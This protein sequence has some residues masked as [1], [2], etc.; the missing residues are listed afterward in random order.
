M[1]Y[2]SKGT[3]G[4]SGFTLIELLVVVAIIA[5]L[6]S[7]LLPSLARARELSKRT[8]CASNMKGIGTGFYTYA[9]ENADRRPEPG[10]HVASTNT[11]SNGCAVKYSEIVGG[12]ATRGTS[13]GQIGSSPD[14]GD[15]G[16][17][18][19]L[20]TTPASLL[21]TTRA[22]WMLVRTNA[23]TPKSFYCPSS[24]DTP[25]DEDNPQAYWDFGKGDNNTGG[26][27]YQGA[28]AQ[29]SYGYQVPYG[30]TGQPS[31]DND[32]RMA[33][34]A[35]KGPWGT[36][37]EGGK[38]SQP[39]TGTTGVTWT[40]INSTSG[41]DDWRRFNSPNHGGIGDGEG[42]VVLY[43]DS[44]AEFQTKPTAGI[45]QD[46]IYTAWSAANTTTVTYDNIVK[47]IFVTK[48]MSAGAHPQPL[49]GTDSV[50]Y[51]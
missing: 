14:Q 13:R 11:A 16:N 18:A 34:A 43:A 31:S 17:W 21:S 40:A 29:C 35:D 6:I 47:G 22:F 19:G 24:D 30:A 46:N 5:L 27:G 42:Q 39:E 37:V 28:W 26:G 9:N 45:G 2:G 41:P 36:Y 15:P 51:P 44:H 49:V 48:N 33:L 3:A 38:G 8:V 32:A 12:N 4:R 23:S 50:I 25:N 20:P 10:P 1:R 7:I